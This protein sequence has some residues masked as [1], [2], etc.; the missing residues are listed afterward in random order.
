ML[1]F[2]PPPP[3]LADWLEGAV[4][5][6]AGAELPGTHFPAMTASLLVVRLAGEVWRDDATRQ[7][8]PPAAWMGPATRPSAYAHAGAVHAVGL[9][10][11]AAAA[12]VLCQL[13]GA[14]RANHFEAAARA[15]G[16]QWAQTE[17]AIR[18]QHTNAARIAT[19]FAYVRTQAALPARKERLRE[20]AEL[21]TDLTQYDVATTADRL[22]L[23]ARQLER[24]CRS[25]FGMTP[26][27]VQTITRLKQTLHQGMGA[28]D[29]RADLAALQGYYDQS[30]LGR[31]VRRLLGHPLAH[32][33]A[34]LLPAASPGAGPLSAPING[35][36]WPLAVRTDTAPPTPADPPAPL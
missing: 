24:R 32:A 35:A 10:V 6:C 12:G 19:L 33:A 8:L 20:R 22:K 7:P 26:K 34:Q 29:S 14:V 9:I 15:L 36:L 4:C 16:P 18:A 28:A 31:D 11:R 13:P 30:H 23:S 25:A 21:L 27:Q 2:E 3:D 1:H 5:V 17:A